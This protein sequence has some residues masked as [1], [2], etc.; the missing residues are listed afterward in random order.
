MDTPEGAQVGPE[1]CARSLAAVAMD[2]ALTVTIAIPRPFAQPVRHRGMARMTAP[3]TLP[4]IRIEQ[5]APG[6]GRCQQ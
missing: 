2:L 3:V 5:R 6:G 4:F 1:R